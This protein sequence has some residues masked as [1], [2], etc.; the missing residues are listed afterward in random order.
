MGVRGVLRGCRGLV[1]CRMTPATP[2]P[3]PPTPY[4][5]QTLRLSAAL[6]LLWL[7]VTLG[8][9]V[10]GRTTGFNFFGWPF[11]FW[12]TSQ[13]ALAVFCAIVWYYAWAMNRLDRRHG[14]VEAD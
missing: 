9:G 2:P 5:R 3:S 1:S 6:L 8:V 7:A 10:F 11:G 13:G 4:W 12:A 14:Q